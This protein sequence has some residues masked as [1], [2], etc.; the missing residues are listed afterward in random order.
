MQGSTTYTF[1]G[2]ALDAAPYALRG[3]QA[4]PDYTRQQF[5]GSV[6][7]P[8]R[9]PGVYDGA[10]TTYFVNYNGGRSGNFIDQYATVPTAAMR[11]GDFSGLSA[12]ID[13]R[14]GQPFPNGA[15]P[16]DRIDPAARALLAYIPL[17]NLPGSSQNF[18]RTATSATTSD[19]ISVRLTHNFGATPQRGQGGRGGFG[20]GGGR[21]GRGGQGRGGNAVGAE[22]AGAVSAQPIGFGQCV[23][24]ARRRHR[25]V[26]ALGAHPGQRAA[27]AHHP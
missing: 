23:P 16:A 14:T 5:G 18:R 6:G 19:G 8:L 27:R 10:R 21:G 17:P 13:P 12:P 9:V 24:A 3:T 11:A 4:T 7:G 26:V 25:D 20:G 2:S 1:G 22:R 15:I